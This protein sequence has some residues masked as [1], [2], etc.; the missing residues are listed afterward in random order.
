MN[1]FNHSPIHSSI[2][3]FIHPTVY[4][5]VKK[6]YFINISF[7]NSFKRSFPALPSNFSIHL[8]SLDRCFESDPLDL[9][10]FSHSVQGMEI[11][12]RCLLS[13]CFLRSFFS[14]SFQHSVHLCSGFCLTLKPEVF[15]IIVSILM[16]SSCK[17]LE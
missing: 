10:V 8:C 11:P 1:P 6:I 15:S 5:S 7:N 2:H 9:K 3:S 12:S 16:L 14:A 17:L 4:Y 13:M